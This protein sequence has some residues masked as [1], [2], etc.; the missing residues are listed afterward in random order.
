[1]TEQVHVTTA[2]KMVM[3]EAAK[4]VEEITAPESVT[5]KTVC[6]VEGTMSEMISGNG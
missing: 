1:M 4:T 6:A 2:M 5:M 3:I